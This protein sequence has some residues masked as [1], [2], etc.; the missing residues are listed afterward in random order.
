MRL[1][2]AAPAKQL[3]RTTSKSKFRISWNI[4]QETI[5]SCGIFHFYA[6][7]FES[8]ADNEVVHV[9]NQVVAGY[10]VED[11]LGDGYS[12]SFVFYYYFGLACFVVD[13]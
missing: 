9:E 10:L 3:L 6:V 13:Y 8:V 4:L 7:V 5:F 12:G 11:L 2:S 1:P